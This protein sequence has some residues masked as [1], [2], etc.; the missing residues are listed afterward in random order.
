MSSV[1]TRRTSTDAS[2]FHDLQLRTLVR[3]LALLN[4]VCKLELNQICAD[5]VPEYKAVFGDDSL[6]QVTDGD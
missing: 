2:L 3:T 1:F 4:D 5:L 6:E